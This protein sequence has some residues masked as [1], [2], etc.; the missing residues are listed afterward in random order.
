MIGLVYFPQFSSSHGARSPS[1][2]YIYTLDVH[3]R[4][5]Y[6]YFTFP[7]SSNVH[8]FVLFWLFSAIPAL[9]SRND[10]IPNPGLLGVVSALADVQLF[11]GSPQQAVPD[12][13]TALGGRKPL[14][15]LGSVFH[16]GPVDKAEALVSGR[17]AGQ[18][19]GDNPRLAVEVEDADLDDGVGGRG[20]G[21]PSQELRG[22]AGEARQAQ[23]HKGHLRAGGEE[24]ECQGDHGTCDDCCWLPQGLAA[25][26][27]GRGNDDH[28]ED[29]AHEHGEFEHAKKGRPGRAAVVDDQA[30]WVQKAGRLLW[31]ILK[32]WSGF[33]E[34]PG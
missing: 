20:L 27:K 15:G 22:G 9:D 16:D 33:A 5:I 32:P 8:E 13:E 4:W 28:Y 12:G 21:V 19:Q 1:L 17:E 26:V 30:L 31:C 34:A 7:S 25:A 23:A 2:V 11:E 3:E 10:G 24:G 29:G 6:I 18:R 14:V